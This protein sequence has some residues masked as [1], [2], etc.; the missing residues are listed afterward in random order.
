MVSIPKRKKAVKNFTNQYCKSGNIIK[1][2][3]DIINKNV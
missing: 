1:T 2:L 3:T